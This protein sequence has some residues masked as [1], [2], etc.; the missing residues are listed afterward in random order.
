MGKQRK[1]SDLKT[2]EKYIK[3]F[4]NRCETEDMKPSDYNLRKFLG[5]SQSTLDRYYRGDKATGVAKVRDRKTGEMVNAYHGYDEVLKDLISYR[6]HYYATMLDQRGANVAGAI[7]Q[8]KQLKNGGYTDS[9]VAVQG[10]ATLT[11]R[12]EGVGGMDAFK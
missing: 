10:N 3:D 8:L 12:V 4:I 6:E 9:P 7:I 2:F 1:V 11:L 5:I